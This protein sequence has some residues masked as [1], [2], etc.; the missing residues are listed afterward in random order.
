MCRQVFSDFGFRRRGRCSELPGLPRGPLGS[1][2]YGRDIWNVWLWIGL[3]VLSGHGVMMLRAFEVIR[4]FRVKGALM[5]INV[6]VPSV[7]S[8][9]AQTSN[10]FP[11]YLDISFNKLRL[12][13]RA[14]RWI[15]M[16]LD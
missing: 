3:F 15:I 2:R 4:I 13:R 8:V 5:G 9:W 6:S 1:R 16:S 11:A 7:V 14:Y 10:G 12:N